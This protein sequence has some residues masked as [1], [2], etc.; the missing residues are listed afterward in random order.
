MATLVSGL[1]AVFSPFGPSTLATALT[2]AV[3]TTTPSAD[4]PICLACSAVLT[5]KPTQT[6]KSVWPLIRFT[7][8][9]TLP[10]SASAEPV[11]P[12]IET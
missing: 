11:M 1:S 8:A 12:V 3:P 7:A 5:P 10:V 4:A 6:G 9:A 2:I